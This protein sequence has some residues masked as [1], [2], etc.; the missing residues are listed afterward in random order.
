MDSLPPQPLGERP[1]GSA[2]RR[3]PRAAW[4]CWQPGE[5]PPGS[6]P[7]RLPPAASHLGQS[8]AATGKAQD[9]LWA[10][11]T[12]RVP[13]EHARAREAENPTRTWAPE[14]R[15]GA[16]VARGGGAPAKDHGSPPGSHG[17]CWRRPRELGSNH[18]TRAA[19]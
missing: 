7:K 9:R 19:G 10:E 6:A 2:P 18:G 1:P 5:R 16:H 13:E 17:E 11:E 12:G 3:L 8:R 14:R 15:P 4:G